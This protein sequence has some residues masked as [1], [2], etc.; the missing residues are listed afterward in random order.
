MLGVLH[1]NINYQPLKSV[2]WNLLFHGDFYYVAA[3]FY[4]D[5][6]DS[7]TSVR[8]CFR[9]CLQ[10]GEKNVGEGTGFKVMQAGEGGGREA[11]V[12]TTISAI[13]IVNMMFLGGDDALLH[14]GN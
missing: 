3:T 8:T 2:Y 1:F 10:R 7:N 6:V 13:S 5:Q 9:C 12:L 14:S 11:I 4:S